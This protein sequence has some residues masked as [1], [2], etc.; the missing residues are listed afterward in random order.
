MLS[1]LNM[2]QNSRIV[3]RMLTWS[4]VPAHG[5]ATLRPKCL[6]RGCK[7][8]PSKV[9]FH[10]QTILAKLQDLPNVEAAWDRLEPF[11]LRL[12]CS[13]ACSD[14]TRSILR[15]MWQDDLVA[16]VHFIAPLVRLSCCHVS[17]HLICPWGWTDITH[18]HSFLG[19]C[20]PSRC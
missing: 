7:T 5:P 11:C 20:K 10:G 16:V 15:Y 2:T 19:L 17:F 1:P 9:W 12:P 18:L 13:A 3:Y 8:D 14:I 4:P 6:Q